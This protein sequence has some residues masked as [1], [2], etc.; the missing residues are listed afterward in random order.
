MIY[1]ENNI[2]LHV[3]L[4]DL[5]ASRDIFNKKSETKRDSIL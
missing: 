3:Q 1:Q 5:F 4:L 2:K